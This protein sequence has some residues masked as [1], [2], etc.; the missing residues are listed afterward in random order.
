M[1]E[2]SP[3]PPD[4]LGEGELR[5]ILRRLT[6]ADLLRAALACRRWRR[7]AS[8]ALPR[9]PPL[10]GYFFHPARPS[11]PPPMPTS[12][13][14]FYPAAFVPLDAAASP[15]LSA[16]LDPADAAKFSLQDVHLGLALLL[17][18]G[19]PCPVLPRILAVDPAS[20]RRALLPPPP[21]AALP[22]DRWRRDRA[23]IG[24]ALLSRAH[25][26]RLSFEAVCLTVDGGRPRA[27]VASVADGD[28][29]WRALP[30]A[31]GVHVDFDPWWFEARCV[32]AAGDIFWHICD[33]SRLLKLDPRTL[34]F[35]F[36]PVPA[37]V[38]DRFK[39]YRLGETPEDGR[40]CMVVA[41]DDM[42]LQIWVRGEA[43]WGDRG[44]LLE[45]RM[46]IDKVLDAVPG[47]PGDRMNRLVC[48]W[49]SDLDY[50]RTGRVFIQTWGYGRYSFHMET[51]ELERLEMDDGKEYGHPIYA[52]HLAWPPAF[53]SE[54][55]Y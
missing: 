11:G 54:E 38:G 4:V 19:R 35:S 39:K 51:G 2:P 24:V 52:Y 46:C 26:S 16:A 43:R 41:D 47:L 7:A 13:K 32:H 12:D 48:T 1:E 5:L 28:C 30:R 17:P 8:R 20:R 50:A 10:L 31:E 29:T 22:D 40:L 18:L 3:S 33:S 27:W 14:T 36:L 6:P 37:Q 9:A 49:V 21:R 42:D 44:W 34:Q 23:V 55:E 15:R 45:R 53:L 25:P